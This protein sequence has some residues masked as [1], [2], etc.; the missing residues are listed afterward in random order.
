MGE[1]PFCVQIW[2]RKDSV[3]FN[4]SDSFFFFKPSNPHATYT[5]PW[6]PL[7]LVEWSRLKDVCS[8]MRSY[9]WLRENWPFFLFQCSLGSDFECFIDCLLQHS[10]VCLMIVCNLQDGADPWW[11]A[12]GCSPSKEITCHCTF[13]A[14]LQ[15]TVSSWKFLG[16]WPTPAADEFI[17]FSFIH[18]AHI[19]V[20]RHLEMVYIVM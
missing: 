2:E 5:E 19:H 9:S 12:A 4:K 20:I 11:Q 7:C 14:P 6:V 10:K 18:I 3:T 1:S 13:A 15:E 17:Q 8:I 16:V